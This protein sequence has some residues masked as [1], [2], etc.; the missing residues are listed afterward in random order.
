[1]TPTGEWWSG[2]WEP[3]NG[4][5]G[6]EESAN[7]AVNRIYGGE[8]AEWQ[9]RW[10]EGSYSSERWTGVGEPANGAANRIYGEERAERQRRALRWR[11]A[12]F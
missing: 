1:M 9:A 2:V 7:G 12:P 4:G 8:R 3:A 10:R 6:W 11:A 5:E